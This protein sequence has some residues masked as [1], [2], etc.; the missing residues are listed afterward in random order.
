MDVAGIGPAKTS[1]PVQLPLVF[2]NTPLWAVQ[3]PPS[4]IPS[5]KGCG[6]CWTLPVLKVDKWTTCLNVHRPPKL[7]RTWLNFGILCHSQ[8]QRWDLTFSCQSHVSFSISVSMESRAGVHRV[9]SLLLLLPSYTTKFSDRDAGS[10]LLN[11]FHCTFQLWPP[12]KR[13]CRWRGR[14]GRSCGGSFRKETGVQMWKNL[15]V[16]YEKKDRPQRLD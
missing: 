14:G 4:D 1:D 16:P 7:H 10:C 11:A 12:M 9:I 13:S 3:G 5:Y 8:Q 2:L 6:L 15:H